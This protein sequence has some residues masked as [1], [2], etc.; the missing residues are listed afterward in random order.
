MAGIVAAL[1]EQDMADLAAYFASQK[2]SVGEAA[3]DQV[4][5]GESIYRAGDPERGVAACSAC[6]GPRGSGNPLAK[7]PALSGQH[8]DYI[9]TQLQQ[10]RSGERAN[11]DKSIMRSIAMKLTD[12]QIEAISQYVQGLH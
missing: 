6:H 8:A 11:D 4:E 10:F 9:A 7:F 3:A 2:A 12:A 1:S 5:L